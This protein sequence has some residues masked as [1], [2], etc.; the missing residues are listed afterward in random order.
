MRLIRNPGLISAK[1]LQQVHFSRRMPLHQQLLIIEDGM[2][3]YRE[4]LVED[5]SSFCKLWL[6]PKSLKI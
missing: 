6:V 5:S 4:P 2:I 3:V 1:T